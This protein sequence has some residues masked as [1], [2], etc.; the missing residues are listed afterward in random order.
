MTT[1]YTEKHTVF[2]SITK[3]Q[4]ICEKIKPM[5]TDYAEKTPLCFDLCHLCSVN[6]FVIE[7][8]VE[9]LCKCLYK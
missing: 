8:L 7:Q 4:Q 2:R 1:I 6:H 9:T 5:E 3:K